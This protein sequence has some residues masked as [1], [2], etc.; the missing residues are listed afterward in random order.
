M[1]LW[2]SKN[3]PGQA[4][5]DEERSGP[6]VRGALVN[7]VNAQS[8]D[9]RGEVMEPVQLHFR[10]PPVVAVRP[11]GGMAPDRSEL[12]AL[13]PAVPVDLVRPSCTGEPV[14]EIREDFV[15]NLDAKRYGGRGHS[16]VS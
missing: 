5:L 3:E 10:R 2:N 7:E 15:R 12:R 16:T 14:P 4:V 13:P 8:A 9:T 11:I 1:I 6:I